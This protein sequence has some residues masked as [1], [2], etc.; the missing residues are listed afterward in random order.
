[1]RAVV[2]GGAGFIGSHVCERLLESVCDDVVCV[3]NF[4]TGEPAN[5]ARLTGRAG[6]RLLVSD[7]V[8]GLEIDGPVDAVLHFASPA[9][10]A[11]YLRHPLATLRVGAEGTRHALELAAAHGARFVLASTSEAYGDP[12]VHPQP[13]SYWG[14]VN[15]VGPRSCYDEAKRY[16]E[17]LTMAYRRSL[18]VDAGI[19][20]IFNTFGPRMRP[21]DG[22]VVPN[23]IRQAL[24]EAP[25]TVTGDGSQTRSLCYVDDLVDGVLRMLGASIS[26]PV[27]LGNPHEVTMLELAHWI[28]RLTGSRSA[29]VQVPLPED[30]PRRRR[31]DIALAAAELGWQPRTPVEEGLLRTIE[32]FAER[33]K[34]AGVLAEVAA[35]A[36]APSG[37]AVS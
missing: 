25:M 16:A 34:G 20:R 1:M 36:T 7:V 22:R 33:R 12:Q 17:A 37:L 10:P 9:S 4:I 19:V 23:L 2:T 15:P 11:D 27:N 3:D 29:I 31:P 18:G 24:E 8:D 5:I 32:W 30:D 14:N 13:E 26:G 21:G 35:P 28:R 6:F